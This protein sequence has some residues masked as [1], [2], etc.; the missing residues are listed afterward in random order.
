MAGELWLSLLTPEQATAS[1]SDAEQCW[2]D[3]AAS[4]VGGRLADLRVSE[5]WVQ[6]YMLGAT[7]DEDMGVAVR[8]HLWEVDLLKRRLKCS[9]WPDSQHRVVRGTWYIDRGS[10][11]AP[12]K[13]GRRCR[14]L[15][16]LQLVY[17]RALSVKV[18]RHSNRQQVCMYT[19]GGA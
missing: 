9:Y 6:D 15:V 14:W 19:P 18:R 3:S 2:P 7:S 5:F 17:I 12:L 11:Y 8:G 1:S 4:P 16:G 13:V 10:G